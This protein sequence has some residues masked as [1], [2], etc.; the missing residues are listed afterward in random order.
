[1]ANK[2]LSKIFIK[3]TESVK[4]ALKLLSANRPIQTSVPGGIVLIVDKNQTLLGV[5]TDGDIRR[6]LSR[7]VSLNSPI[8]KIMNKDPFVVEGPKTS[9]EILSLAVEKIRK[10][11]F[12]KDR[13]N[14]IIVVNE[15]RQVID[16]ISFYDLWQHSDVRFKQIGVVG[17]GYVGLTLALTLADLGFQVRGFD[18][19]KEVQASL[20]AGKP[21]FFENGLKEILKDNINKNFQVADNFRGINNCD[22]YFIAVGTPLQKDN[23]PNTSYLK[24]ATEQIGKVLKNGDAIILRSTVPIGITRNFVVPNLEKVSGLK[25]GHDFFVAFAPERT[26][27]GKALQ[28]LR[29]LPQVI[30]GINRSSTNLAASVFNYITHSTVLVDSLEEAEMTKLI[31]NTYRDVTF[32]FSNE[33]SLMCHHFG[34][35][36]HRVI[37]AANRGYSRSNVPLPSPGVGGACLEKDPFILLASARTKNLNPLLLQHARTVSDMMVDFVADE[38]LKF[39][40]NHKA[41]I[42]NPKILILGFAFKGRPETSD[43]RGSTTIPLVKKLQKEVRNIYGYDP[44]VK[45]SDITPLKVKYIS[46]LKKG[47]EDADAVIIMNNNPAF[48]TLNI[49]AL[50]SLSNKP[51]FLF[52]TWG[53]YGKEEIQKVRGIEYKKL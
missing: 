48:E 24:Q 51:C 27:E 15:D 12:Y 53:L 28:E 4:A 19:N 2:N 10:E 46:D 22:I 17:L 37:E 34:I 32:A 50:L 1:M 26:I 11:N 41:T 49:R 8:S 40:K 21:H 31:N 52:D 13:L 35:D 43:M 23:K 47:F 36:T 25:A 20:K 39:I 16:L 5:A 33:L 45:R 29:T 3:P 38:T 6:A 30:G 7:G 9:T 44:V 14:K 42:K 18:A